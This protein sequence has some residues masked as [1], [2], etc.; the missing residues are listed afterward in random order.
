M[1]LLHANKAEW[2]LDSS[3]AFVSQLYKQVSN[4]QRGGGLASYM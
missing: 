3:T 4:K 1:R 2:I